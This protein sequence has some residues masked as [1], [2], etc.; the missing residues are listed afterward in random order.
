MRFVA[1]TFSLTNRNLRYFTPQELSEALTH[2]RCTHEERNAIRA[3]LAE[4]K[5]AVEERGAT[6]PHREHA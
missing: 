6:I 3:A 1:C 2:L 5:S 4:L